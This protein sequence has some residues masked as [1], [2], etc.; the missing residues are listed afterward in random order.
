MKKAQSVLKNAVNPDYVPKVRKN[1]KVTPETGQALLTQEDATLIEK[2]THEWR[3]QRDISDLAFLGMRSTLT[4]WR[5]FLPEYSTL[6]LDT[7]YAGLNAAKDAGLAD[8]TRRNQIL[9]LKLFLRWL[10]KKNV[11]QIDKD[12]IDGLKLPGKI[13]KKV[14]DADILTIDEIKALI[15]ACKTPRDRALIRTLY[16]TGCRINEIC[17]LTWGQVEFNKH[18]AAIKVRS[19]TEKER[20]I[21]LYESAEPLAT[22]K[23]VYPWKPVKDDSYV[24]PSKKGTLFSYGGV[25]FHLQELAK[26]AGITKKIRPHLFRHSRITHLLQTGMSES[27]VKLVM[28]GDI[29]SKMFDSYAHLTG[30]DVS[31]EYAR[32]HGI[33][34]EDWQNANPMEPVQC[35]N[36]HRVHPAGTEFCSKC[37]ISLSEEAKAEVHELV[38]ITSEKLAEILANPV[39]SKKVQAVLLELLRAEE[40]A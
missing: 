6:T 30:E 14:S 9:Y 23:S 29:N 18:A 27:A 40:S 24:F 20:Y 16:E 22:W 17:T 37:G 36:C 33:V 35:P 2:F 32:M 10:V 39:K 3:A 4:G 26:Q 19:K 12:D 11:I 21:P 8:S 15:D 5:R 34:T 28:W 7:L 38:D 25:Y 1:W 31:R 13:K